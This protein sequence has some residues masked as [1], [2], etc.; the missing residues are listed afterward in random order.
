MHQP[1]PKMIAESAHT[2]TRN[3]FCILIWHWQTAEWLPKM[4][5]LWVT[6]ASQNIYIYLYLEI[7]CSVSKMPRRITGLVLL[8]T[9]TRPTNTQSTAA[10][11]M[12]G[13]LT[14]PKG[15]CHFV[16]RGLDSKGAVQLVRIIFL[17][18]SNQLCAQQ[19]HV[20]EGK[21]IL[22]LLMHY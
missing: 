15:A 11:N 5:L 18:F 9:H 7:W 16:D 4:D 21:S 6:S 10:N 19:P 17:C 8:L 2:V 22:E 1:Q 14:C 20:L 12:E 13:P 3:N